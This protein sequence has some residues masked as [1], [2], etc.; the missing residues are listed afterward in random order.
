MENNNNLFP[1]HAL[2]PPEPITI[3]GQQ[4]F[5]IDKIV[6]EWQHGKKT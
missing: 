3:N 2:I 1:S 4:E 5:F 6:D